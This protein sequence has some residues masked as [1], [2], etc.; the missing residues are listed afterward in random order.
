MNE[1]EISDILKNNLWQPHYYNVL[2]VDKLIHTKRIFF[3][4]CIVINTGASYT[5]GYHWQCLYIPDD[6]K[7]CIFFVVWAE[8]Q[9]RK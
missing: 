2:P 9:V 1:T 6:G 4:A 8:N 3:P 7:I 5:R